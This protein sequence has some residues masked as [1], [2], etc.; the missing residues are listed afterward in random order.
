MRQALVWTEQAGVWPFI[1][2]TEYSAANACDCEVY[3]EID[4][5]TVAGARLG[6]VSQ[7]ADFQGFPLSK[8]TLVIILLVVLVAFAYG[9]TVALALGSGTYVVAWLL[10][11]TRRAW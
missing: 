8:L 4:N 2:T 5:M 10:M 7:Y 1:E 3:S 6:R 11:S 9:F